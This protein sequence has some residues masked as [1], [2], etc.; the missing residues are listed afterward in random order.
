[1]YL[2]KKKKNYF[3]VLNILYN[4]I[5]L[6]VTYRAHR[7]EQ[8]LSWVKLAVAMVIPLI[9]IVALRNCKNNSSNGAQSDVITSSNRPTTKSLSNLPSLELNMT[10]RLLSYSLPLSTYSMLEVCISV[11]FFVFFFWIYLWRPLLVIYVIYNIRVC[12]SFF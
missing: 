4:F 9:L 8:V 5:D 7:E 2:K 12:N 3:S 11:F 1:M 10:W 6:F